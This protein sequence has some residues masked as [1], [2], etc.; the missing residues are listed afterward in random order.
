MLICQRQRI[1]FVIVVVVE[2]ALDNG[3]ASSVS[4]SLVKSIATVQDDDG[5]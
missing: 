1:S 5:E 2:L 3:T 4:L